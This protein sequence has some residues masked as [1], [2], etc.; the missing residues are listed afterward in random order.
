[1]ISFHHLTIFPRKKRGGAGLEPSA[2]LHIK[3]SG[4]L[5]LLKEEYAIFKHTL[6]HKTPRTDP[7]PI[8]VF[9]III[10]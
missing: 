10:S 8:K 9:A 6:T 3:S 5:L 7:L 4:N 2:R 1:M